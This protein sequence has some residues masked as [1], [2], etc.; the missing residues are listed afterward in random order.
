[1]ERGYQYY[2]LQKERDG[3]KELF[4]DVAVSSKPIMRESAYLFGKGR[5]RIVVMFA[6][7]IERDEYGKEY[8]YCNDTGSF[9]ESTVLEFHIDSLHDN[10]IPVDLD[11]LN[12]NIVSK[13]MEQ[14]KDALQLDQRR[15][16]QK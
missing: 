6:R 5:Y 1:M 15:S 11:K 2:K 13:M 7:Y 9:H 3:V 4:D 10:P 16:I 8:K 14:V 12:L